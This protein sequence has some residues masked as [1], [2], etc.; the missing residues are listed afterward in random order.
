VSERLIVV[1]PKEAKRKTL[2]RKR[3]G[4][5]PFRREA[6]GWTIRYECLDGRAGISAFLDR[7]QHTW[8]DAF[9][10][11]ETVSVRFGRG[12]IRPCLIKGVEKTCGVADAAYRVELLFAGPSR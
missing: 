10:S 2:L 9:Y 4:E 5:Y 7:M 3:C 1:D 11:G 8:A 6:F 12:K